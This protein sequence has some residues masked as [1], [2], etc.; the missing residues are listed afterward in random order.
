[1]AHSLNSSSLPIQSM[2]TRYHMLSEG[3]GIICSIING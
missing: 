3:T 1:M 2:C